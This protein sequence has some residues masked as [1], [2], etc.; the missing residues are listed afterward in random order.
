MTVSGISVG[1]VIINGTRGVGK[2]G[3]ESNRYANTRYVICHNN[4]S[5]P[6]KDIIVTVH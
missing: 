6:D 2:V 3:N 4:I 5:I 1:C